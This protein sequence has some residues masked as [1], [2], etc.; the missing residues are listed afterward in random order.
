MSEKILCVDDEINVLEGYRRALRKQYRLDLASGGE[1]GLEKIAAGGPYAVVVSDMRMPGMD[2]VR[3][4]ARVRQTAPDTVRVMLTGNADM[5][6]AIEAVNEGNIFRF[7]TKPCPPETLSKALEAGLRQYRLQTAE[8]VLLERTLAG[9]VKVLTEVLGLVNPTAFGRASR[10]KRYVGRIVRELELSDAW[11]YELA[12]LLSQLGCVI[13][14]PETMEKVF[15]GQAL[16]AEEAEAFASHPRVGG[17]LL[18]NIPRLE[19]VARI[20]EAQHRSGNAAGFEQA[21]RNGEVIEIG[22]QILKAVL[23]FDRLTAGGVAVEKALAEMR[24][25]QDEY[26]QK[27][28]RLLGLVEVSGTGVETR[29]ITVAEL[30]TNMIL[31]EEVRAENGALLVAEGQEVTYPVLERLRNFARGVGVREPFRVKIIRCQAP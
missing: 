9:S 25:R 18:S 5:S 20:I 6:T 19:T 4:F 24:R 29:A 17:R 15:V 3:F 8:K 27:V 28:L 12:A 21:V 1:E 10:L 30:D 16:N 26:P 11:L 31:A 7:L 22:A 2:G 14:P 13:L 23:D